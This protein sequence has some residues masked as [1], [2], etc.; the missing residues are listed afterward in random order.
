MRKT[1]LAIL[2]VLSMALVLVVVQNT[3]L[4]QGRFLWFAAEV[5]VI[6]L[7]VLTT[8]GGF[9]LGLLV[10]IFYPRDKRPT[11]QPR[12]PGE[13]TERVYRS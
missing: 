4:V 2:L 7:L 9:V 10:A 11:V 6:L 8:A 1:K 13:Y 3:T 5:P 12:P